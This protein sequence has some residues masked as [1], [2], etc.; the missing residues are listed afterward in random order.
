[1]ICNVEIKRSKE[2]EQYSAISEARCAILNNIDGE[3]IITSNETGEVLF[4]Y[5]HR[6]IKWM[7]GDFAR[8]LFFLIPLAGRPGDQSSNYTN[9]V[10]LFC[11]I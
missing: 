6:A 11:T 2:M 5:D 10:D 3:I 7:D 4:H 8:V 9:W 1:M